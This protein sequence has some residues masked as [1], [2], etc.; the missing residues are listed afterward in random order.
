MNATAASNAGSR[1]RALLASPRCEILLEA[2]NAVSARL[3]EEAGVPG[4]WAS[5]LTLSCAAGLRD[6][7]SLSSDQALDVLESMTARVAVPVLF[8]G[9]TGYGDFSHFQTLVRRLI[10]RRVAGVCIEDKAFPKRNSFLAGE[11]QELAD[12]DEFCGKLRAGLDA[13]GDPS[14]VVVART[15]A[16]I[17]GAGLDEALRRAEAYADQGVD[18]VLVHSKAGTFGELQ[19]FM[20]RFSRRVP[21][22]CVPTTYYQTP[23]E[24]FDAAGVSLALWANHMLRASVRAMHDVAVRIAAERG[25]RAVEDDVAP[26]SELF[27]L[28]DQQ[29]FE[30]Q[31]RLYAAGPQQR[32]IVLAASRGDG[33]DSLT[34]DRPKCMLPVAGVPVLDRLLTQLRAEGVRDLTVVRGYR[35]EAVAPAGVR[36][37]T[38]PGWAS[39]G[40]LRSLHAAV[41]SLHGDVVVAYGDLVLRRHVLHELLACDAPLSVVVDAA[42]GFLESGRAADRVRVSGPP[43]RPGDD[44]PRFLRDVSATLP[45]DGCEGEWVGLLRARGAGAEA[46]RAALEA[47]LAEPGGEQL[48]MDALMRR[49]LAQGHEIRALHV[50]GGWADLDTLTDLAAATP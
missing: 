20:A 10:A 4:V 5:S 7:G 15:E 49:L 50:D 2:H 37:V 14:F 44:A 6:N 23:P 42:R 19:A 3:V 34:R 17:T 11:R 45:D 30:A 13:R 46:L 32:A 48:A 41:E 36:L 25:G 9:D 12:L 8:D 47:L 16:L 24:A 35:P 40:E 39:S 28:S 27:R 43:P 1:L 38:N 21:V 18:A 22:V 33:F 31:E 26:L 29:A